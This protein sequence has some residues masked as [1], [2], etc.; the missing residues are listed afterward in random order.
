MVSAERGGEGGGALFTFDTII[1]KTCN[2]E[3]VLP[4]QLFT[5]IV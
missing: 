3:H 5:N 1:R 2:T 4:Q